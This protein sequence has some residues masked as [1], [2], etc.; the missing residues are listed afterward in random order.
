M[1]SK[2]VTEQEALLDALK[3]FA[4]KPAEPSS[5][6]PSCGYCKECGRSDRTVPYAPYQSYPRYPTA[7]YTPFWYTNVGAGTADVRMDDYLLTRT[8]GVSEII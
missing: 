4:K 6:Y 8:N 5:L 3:E 1:E 7:P 2:D